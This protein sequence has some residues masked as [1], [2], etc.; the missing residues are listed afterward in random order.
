MYIGNFRYMDDDSGQNTGVGEWHRFDW[1]GKQVFNG[2]F[3]SGVHSILPHGL[4]VGDMVEIDVTYGSD[5]Y[6]GVRKVIFI[7]DTDDGSYYDTLFG[8]DVPM[9]AGE[10][11]SGFYRQVPA[12]YN[13]GSGDSLPGSI[14]NGEIITGGIGGISTPVAVGLGVLAAGI[15]IVLM[16]QRKKKG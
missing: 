11:A 4:R 12:N 16:V 3:V 15:G 1:I 10:V 8:I 6:A 9:R 2:Y 14:D 5:K 7:G 13:P